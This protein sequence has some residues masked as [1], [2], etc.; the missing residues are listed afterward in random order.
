MFLVLLGFTSWVYDC[1]KCTFSLVIQC[2]HWNNALSRCL[3]KSLVHIIHT[4]FWI[5]NILPI[6]N[7]KGFIIIPTVIM[8]TILLLHLKVVSDSLPISNT[9]N[10]ILYTVW[11]YICVI[12]LFIYLLY[13]CLSKEDMKYYFTFRTVQIMK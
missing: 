11:W 10:S 12:D 9:Y 8:S 13:F 4:Y 7:S 6:L 2:L 3:F 5:V 1:S